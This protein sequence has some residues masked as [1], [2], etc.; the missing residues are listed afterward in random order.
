MSLASGRALLLPLARRFP[1]PR[2]LLVAA[3]LWMLWILLRFVFVSL[4]T[5]PEPEAP[6]G[7]PEAG[8]IAGPVVVDI[9]RVAVW[10]LFG[11]APDTEAVNEG[12]VEPDLSAAEEAAE[13]TRLA[14]QLEGVILSNRS[15]RGRARYC[16]PGCAGQL[17]GGRYPTRRSSR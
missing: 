14:L 12:P 17:R 16:S 2:L 7:E 8:K 1:A 11:G 4:A 6:D 10:A 9:R 13:Q 5:S 3:C 15:D